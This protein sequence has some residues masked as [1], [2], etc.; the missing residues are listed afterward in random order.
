MKKFLWFGMVLLFCITLSSCV[1]PSSR[2][3]IALLPEERI[4]TAPAGQVMHLLLDGKP[5]DITFPR[6][7]KVVDSSILVRQEQQLNDALIKS[8]K[9]EKTQG[10]IMSFLTALFGAIGGIFA[11][12]AKN[13]VTKKA[14]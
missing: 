6:D 5:I 4:F 11:V 8:I 1:S 14:T 13:K 2:T 10:G 9:A 12:W 7:M 3:K